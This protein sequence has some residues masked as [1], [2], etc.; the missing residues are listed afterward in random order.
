MAQRLRRAFVAFGVDNG[1]ALAAVL[2]EPGVI[3]AGVLTA[4]LF[5]ESLH[6]LGALGN[7]L[8][9]VRDARLLNPLLNVLRV[10]VDVGVDVREHLLKVGRELG[11]IWL[12]GGVAC[13]ERVNA[14]LRLLRRFL[15]NRGG[16][17][18]ISGDAA[19]TTPTTHTDNN[20][21]IVISSNTLR[22]SAS[23]RKGHAAHVRGALAGATHQIAS[24][25]SNAC[26]PGWILL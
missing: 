12:E 26:D 15:C 1:I 10:L 6:H 14:D 19:I 5:E 13:A 23:Y 22:K 25:F 4:E 18:A 3:D 16:L 17:L 24:A 9:A 2:S 7:T 21:A 8:A 20:L 11:I